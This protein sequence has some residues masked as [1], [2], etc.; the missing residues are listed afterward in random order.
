M[1]TDGNELVFSIIDKGETTDVKVIGKAS[2]LVMMVGSVLNDNEDLRVL[3]ELALEAIKADAF[4]Q[5]NIIRTNGD[6]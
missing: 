4:K 3:V 1:S 2:E 5:D 6:A